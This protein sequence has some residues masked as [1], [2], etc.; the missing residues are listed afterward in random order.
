MKRDVSERAKGQALM[1][2]NI[3]ITPKNKHNIIFTQAT[4]TFIETRI[5]MYL[6]GTLFKLGCWCL[7]KE[8]DEATMTITQ[9]VS[10]VAMLVTS[11][12]YHECETQLAPFLWT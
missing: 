4:A 10:T 3:S 12:K 6:Y 2:R 8:K 11:L 9:S 7:H 1:K 5:T